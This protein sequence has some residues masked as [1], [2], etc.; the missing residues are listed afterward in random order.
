MR[1]SVFFLALIVILIISTGCSKPYDFD[2]SKYLTLG[3][4]SGIEV[5]LSETE[6]ELENMIDKLL[7][8]NS[9]ENEV[10]DRAVKEGDIVNIDFKGTLNGEEFAGGSATNYDLEIG[11]G[12]FVE[13][14]EDGIIGKK[15]GDVFDVTTV[16]PEDYTANKDLAGQEVIFNITLNAI[17]EKIV[18]ELT[19]DFIKEKTDY[20]TIEEYKAE[21]LKT[22]KKNYVWNKVLENSSVKEYPKKNV[23]SYYDTMVNSYKGYAINN[24]YTLESF[25]SAS[26]QTMEQFL[27]Q[28][29]EYAKSQVKK[30]MVMYSIARAENIEVDDEEYKEKAPDYAE[31]SGFSSVSEMEKTYSKETIKM[32]ILMDKVVDYTVGLSI[33]KE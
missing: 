28:A 25:L 26:G 15:T 19:D 16:F 12:V 4:Y 17:K 11:S 3:T 14:F 7:D 18:P 20:E 27:S 1:K 22:L 10:T 29:A 9:T 6:S 31:R 2:I 5:S 13:G 33:E 30:E 21:T 23:K 8:E 24:G 32:N